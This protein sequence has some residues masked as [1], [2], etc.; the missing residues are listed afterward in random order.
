M[1]F[2]RD[3]MIAGGSLWEKDKWRLTA[4]SLSKITAEKH[5]DEGLGEG[6]ERR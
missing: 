6:E 4:E 3:G 5:V 1:W 2:L